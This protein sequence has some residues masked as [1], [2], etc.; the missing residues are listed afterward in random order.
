VAR[1]NRAVAVFQAEGPS[2][3]LEALADLEADLDGYHPFHVA[4]SEMLRAIGED[5]AAQEALDRAIAMA[6]NEA[7]RAYLETRAG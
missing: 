1:L 5:G 2:P 6:T 3:G 4:R 7:E